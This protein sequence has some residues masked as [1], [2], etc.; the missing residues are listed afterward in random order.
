MS[1]KVNVD[2]DGKKGIAY[3]DMEPIYSV[4]GR[5]HVMVCPYCGKRM[6]AIKYSQCKFYY[7]QHCLSKHTE[8]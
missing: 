4:D 5:I 3:L 2:I 8:R 1:E 7:D 6:E